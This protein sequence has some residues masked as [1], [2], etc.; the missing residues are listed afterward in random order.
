VTVF[1]KIV[2]FTRYL[3]KNTATNE[4]EPEKPYFMQQYQEKQDGSFVPDNEGK[5]TATVGYAR[6]KV[7][8]SRT[9][10]AIASV[11]SSIF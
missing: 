10:F 2:L 9:S 6:T 3:R 5:D 8:G 1:P 4:V 7:M 11:R